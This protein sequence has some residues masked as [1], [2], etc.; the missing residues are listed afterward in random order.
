[1]VSL[2]LGCEIDADLAS[3]RL[4]VRR[5]LPDPLLPVIE[6]VAKGH[7]LQR[8][9][10]TVAFSITRIV[11]GRIKWFPVVYLIDGKKQ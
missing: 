11:A 9:R 7:L 3:G 4:T 8:R 1:V 6:K 2:A 5:R 10:C